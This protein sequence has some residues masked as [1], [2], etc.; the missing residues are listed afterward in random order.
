MMKEFD[1]NKDGKISFEEY[2]TGICG[3]DWTEVCAPSIS[4]SAWPH[5]VAM[6]LLQDGPAGRTEPITWMIPVDASQLAVKAFHHCCRLVAR[7]DEI[8]VYHVT[9]PS[10]YPAMAPV[11]NPK[12]I[13]SQFETEAIKGDIAMTHKW[14]S[15]PLL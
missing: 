7:G 4:P 5:A 11:F 13:K 14:S 12:V 1:I 3:N 9:N 2:V 6:S 15:K 10:K 8:I